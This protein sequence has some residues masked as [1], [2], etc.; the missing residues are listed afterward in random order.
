MCLPTP[1]R[2]VR[3]ADQLLSVRGFVEC[4]QPHPDLYRFYGRWVHEQCVL[5]GVPVVSQDSH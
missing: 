1:L 2:N 5:D 3:S 4:E